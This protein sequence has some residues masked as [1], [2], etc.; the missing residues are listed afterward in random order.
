MEARPEATSPGWED[1]HE[2]SLVL[3][4]G[5]AYFNTPAGWE[6]KEVGTITGDERGS[7]RARLH[8]TGRDTAFD[9]VVDAPTEQHLI[10][11]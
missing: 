2:V 10:Q 9:L 3:P 5:R 4:A 11:F 8:A 6:M 1:I 7:Y